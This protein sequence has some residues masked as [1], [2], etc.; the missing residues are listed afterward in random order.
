MCQSI[1]FLFRVFLLLY[2]L[3]LQC[4]VGRIEEVLINTYCD[5]LTKYSMHYDRILNSIPFVSLSIHSPPAV[6]LGGPLLRKCFAI[7][8][9]TGYPF[10]NLE[11]N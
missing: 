1:T 2:I 11:A 3:F 7:L 10:A 4:L 8:F 9:L 6:L 5:N